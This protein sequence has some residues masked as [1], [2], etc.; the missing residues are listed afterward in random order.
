MLDTNRTSRGNDKDL[1][2]TMIGGRIDPSSCLMPVGW[3]IWQ[4][5]QWF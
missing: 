2:A 4:C 5:V 3:M 1:Y